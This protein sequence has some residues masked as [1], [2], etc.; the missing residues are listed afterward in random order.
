M[1]MHGNK[2]KHCEKMNILFIHFILLAIALTAQSLVTCI[3]LLRASLSAGEVLSPAESCSR[4]GGGLQSP[5]SHLHRSRS[6]AVVW[7]D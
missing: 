5:V 1:N 6:T 4:E 2:T 3:T 7:Q